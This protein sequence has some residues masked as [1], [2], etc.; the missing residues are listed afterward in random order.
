MPAYTD[1]PSLS[2]DQQFCTVC[3]PCSWAT[4][5]AP[6]VRPL[7]GSDV[8]TD[9]RAFG[10]SVR[11]TSPRSGGQVVHER[12]TLRRVVKKHREVEQKVINTSYNKEQK[13]G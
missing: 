12:A 6:L 5:R 1:P 3:T 10:M 8:S 9:A 13:I 2:A 11:L 4:P 7:T